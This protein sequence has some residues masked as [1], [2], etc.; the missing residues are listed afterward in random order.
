MASRIKET[1]ILYGED[2]RRFVEENKNFKKISQEERERIDKSYEF[3]KS[4]FNEQNIHQNKS[5]EHR[6]G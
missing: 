3:F 1:P 2:A 5:P 6:D 4:I